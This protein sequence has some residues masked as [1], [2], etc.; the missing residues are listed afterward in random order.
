M[1][2][3][4]KSCLTDARHLLTN[5]AVFAV[6]VA[7]GDELLGVFFINVHTFALHVRREISSVVGA[8]V[9]NN[10]CGGKRAFD[11]VH[12]VGNVAGAVGVFDSQNKIAALRLG[13]KISVKSRAQI[14]DVHVTRRARRETCTNSFQGIS[15]NENFSIKFFAELYHV[16]LNCAIMFSSF[17]VRQKNFTEMI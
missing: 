12:G 8:F 6:S 17:E 13:K 10:F 1:K 16:A 7:V 2:H 15:S 14:S 5:R 4:K 3:V 11:E 9:G